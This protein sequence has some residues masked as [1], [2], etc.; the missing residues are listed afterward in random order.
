MRRLI[1]VVVAL[2][3]LGVAV[4]RHRCIERWERE[5]AIGRHAGDRPG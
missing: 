1:F 2:G 4:Y 5:L 3:T